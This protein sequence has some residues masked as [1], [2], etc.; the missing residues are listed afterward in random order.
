MA[1]KKLTVPEIQDTEFK[2]E[3]ETVVN[4]ETEERERFIEKMKQ[5]AAS[6]DVEINRIA[7][8]NGVRLGNSIFAEKY[9]IDEITKTLQ[10]IQSKY[11]SYAK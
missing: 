4:A 5:Y 3:K 10:K 7:S 6:V 8:E 11:L 2:P 1:N 9:A